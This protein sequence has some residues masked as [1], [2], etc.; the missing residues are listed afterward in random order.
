MSAPNEFK[1]S[2]CIGV[3]YVWPIWSK[4]VETYSMRENTFPATILTAASISARVITIWIIIIGNIMEESEAN[5]AVAN[6]FQIWAT[7]RLILTTSKSYSSL[8]GIS[9]TYYYIAIVGPELFQ[10]ELFLPM[11]I[12]GL[13]IWFMIVTTPYHIVTT[14]CI[15]IS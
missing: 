5:R 3:F 7:L 13:W 15:T 6:V 2:N 11:M 4:Q 14:C 1:E 9:D 8:L 12:S 10:K